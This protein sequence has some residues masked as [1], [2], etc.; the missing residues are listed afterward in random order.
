MN[1]TKERFNIFQNIDTLN[2]VYLGW[3]IE[4]S[5][6]LSLLKTD[7]DSL[8]F[9]NKS[10]FQNKAKEISRVAVNLINDLT[11]KEVIIRKE[12]NGKKSE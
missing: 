7:C 11:E 5:E 6:T 10:N 9:D 3:L 12:L 1:E 2:R 8:V 4:V